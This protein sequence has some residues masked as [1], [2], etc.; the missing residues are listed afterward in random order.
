MPLDLF[1]KDS[2]IPDV[3]FELP[4]TQCRTLKWTLCTYENIRD[5]MELLSTEVLEDL[6]LMHDRDYFSDD[7]DDDDGPT[8]SPKLTLFGDSTPRLQSVSL[9][10]LHWAPNNRFSTVTQLLIGYCFWSHPVTTIL[11]LLGGTPQLVDLVLSGM[12]QKQRGEAESVGRAGRVCLK[13][14]RRFALHNVGV[15]G[16]GVALLLSKLDLSP[17]TIIVANGARCNSSADGPW[18][19]AALSRLNL[20]FVKPTRMHLVSC[21]MS[22][23]FRQP[24]KLLLS[25][26]AASRHGGLFSPGRLVSLVDQGYRF[27]DVFPL[28]QVQDLCYL[29]SFYM[30]VEDPWSSR[31]WS[32]ILS[33]LPALE[34]LT[35][36]GRNLPHIAQGLE[37]SHKSG[38][39]SEHDQQPICPRLTR[40]VVFLSSQD[41]HVGEVMARLAAIR[42]RL[43]FSKVT[44]GYLPGYYHDRWTFNWGYHPCPFEAE[45]VDYKDVPP[46]ETPWPDHPELPELPTVYW[47][48]IAQWTDYYCRLP[49]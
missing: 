30:N 28:S 33:E 19:S 5:D 37:D 7:E 34:Q 12:L 25:V 36:L 44:V 20:G 8:T 32:S 24:G 16:D 47:P 6:V 9:Y 21:A 39:G 18:I 46:M 29:E 48:T 2:V 26:V 23:K 22:R 1:F 35:V 45:Y 13:D 41:P 31:M 3:F 49:R 43:P 38:E 42:D 14:L 40:I 27:S 15:A 17:Q 4:K 10:G 11:N